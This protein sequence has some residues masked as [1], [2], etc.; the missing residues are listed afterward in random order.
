MAGLSK[1]GDFVEKISPFLRGKMDVI[2]NSIGIQSPEY[3]A[4]YLQYVRQDIENASEAEAN[5]RHWEADLKIE[6]NSDLPGG[7]ERLY[8]QSAVIEPTMI[9]ASQCRYCL[10]ANYEVFTLKDEELLQIAKYC[11][12]KS[13]S[14]PLS[15]V[16]ITGGDPLIVPKKLRFLIESIIDNSPNIKRIR[17]GTRL[18]LHDP[19][20]IDNDLYD[21]FRCN[22]D[23]VSFEIGSQIN[24][25]VELFPESV[26]VFQ[27]LRSLGVKIYS[28]N[29]L[30]K[31]VNNNI[32]AL[33]GLYRRL[34]EL[35][36]E[37][38]YLFHS[39]PMRGMHHLRTSVGRGLELSTELI[40]SGYISGRI[41]P[42]FALMTDVGKVTLYNGTILEKRDDNYILLKTNYKYDERMKINPSW[43]LPHTASVDKD[44]Y[45]QVLYLDGID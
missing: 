5:Q 20:R 10:R 29:V 45:L 40:N 23:K 4:L 14:D 39:V 44:G 21:I 27:K 38:H 26:E 17:I 43:N 2:K 15:E 37:A 11:S 42:M 19:G 35:D 34:R 8:A 32:D 25:E 30:I 36:I 7:I 13:D 24:H 33:V 12:K 31:G 6:S 3:Q 18:P 41:K 9:C 22:R 28:Q 1:Q 16:L